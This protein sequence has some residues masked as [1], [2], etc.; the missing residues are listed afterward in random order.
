[1]PDPKLIAKQLA[2]LNTAETETAAHHRALC[3]WAASVDRELAAA[4]ADA[5]TNPGSRER[6]AILTQSQAAVADAFAE[7]RTRH[8]ENAENRAALAKFAAMLGLTLEQIQAG[9]C[10]DA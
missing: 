6:L 10:G 5:S 4:R 1:M 3:D 2:I 7:N 9:E 8:T